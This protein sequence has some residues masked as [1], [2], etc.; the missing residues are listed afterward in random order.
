MRRPSWLSFAF[1]IALL[2][3]SIGQAGVLAH[4]EDGGAPGGAAGGAAG[5]GASGGHGQGEGDGAA[6]SATGGSPSSAAGSGST[7]AAGI[8][9]LLYDLSGFLSVS[10][11]PAR[12]GASDARR[13]ELQSEQT[14]ARNAVS[15][16]QI[17]PLS[18]ILAGVEPVAPGSVLTARLKK[19]VTGGW[20]YVLVILSAE[21]R[22]RTVVIDA[23]TNG[24]L[25]IR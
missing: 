4:A 20:I 2:A 22:Y 18:A 12:P 21:G 6:A 5:A 23:K 11:H 7:R 17:L 3:L 8:G 24:I 9:G 16:G 14:L 19:D 1:L 10:P 15:Q 25:Q 13:S